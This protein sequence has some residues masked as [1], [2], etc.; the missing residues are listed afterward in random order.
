MRQHMR[1]MTPY[2][3]IYAHM[4]NRQC[5]YIHED[6]CLTGR[7]F[8]QIVLLGRE[9]QNALHICHVC[10]L[11]ENCKKKRKYIFVYI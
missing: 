8:S 6:I 7:R 11:T 1:I 2:L 10:K 4:S 9:K 3:S 5:I